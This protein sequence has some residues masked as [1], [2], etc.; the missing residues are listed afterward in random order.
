MPRP[1]SRYAKW[2]AAYQRLWPE[3]EYLAFVASAELSRS[4]RLR[5]KDDV[6]NVADVL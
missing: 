2:E 5:S 3:L 4:G 6:E 1:R